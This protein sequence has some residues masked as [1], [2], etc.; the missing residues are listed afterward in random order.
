MAIGACA[1]QFYIIFLCSA[2]HNIALLLTVAK[3]R[4]YA[5][6]A[7]KIVNTLPSDFPELLILRDQ[8]VQR[9]RCLYDRV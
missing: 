2:I 1:V 5:P 3:K 7:H 8:S 9:H 6:E 4:V